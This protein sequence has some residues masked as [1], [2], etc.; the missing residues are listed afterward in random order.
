M[1]KEMGSRQRLCLCNVE[2]VAII[3]PHD[4]TGI[5][6]THSVKDF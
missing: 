5:G 1:L 2:N 3:K 4:F 6:K